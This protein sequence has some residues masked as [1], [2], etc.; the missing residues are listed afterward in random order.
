MGY[1]GNRL[2]TYPHSEIDF[3]LPQLVSMYIMS[4]EVA[5]VIHPYIVHRCRN[6]V[7]FSLRCAWLLDAY[8]GSDLATSGNKKKAQH[9]IKLKNLILSGE[10]V[11]KD[12]T[13]KDKLQKPK[14]TIY[15]HSQ[16]TTTRPTSSR[17]R[18]GHVRS[19]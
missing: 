2:F 16:I 12:N 9:G 4:H 15:T 6:S 19:R 3:Y 5:E 11:P 13:E 8:V 10:L 17:R 18:V 7:D 14:K 1:I